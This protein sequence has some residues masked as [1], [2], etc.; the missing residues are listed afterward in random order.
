MLGPGPGGSRRGDMGSD[1]LSFLKNFLS[2]T[3][4]WESA[5]TAA[6]EMGPARKLPLK[7]EKRFAPS[8]STEPGFFS[9]SNHILR[10]KP[11]TLN[12]KPLPSF[13]I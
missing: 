4:G 13:L 1:F 2:L 6:L 9:H 10:P 3:K 8:P 7:G 5:E 11:K 12:P